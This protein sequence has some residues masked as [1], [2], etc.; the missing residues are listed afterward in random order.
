M[1]KNM[2]QTV[3]FCWAEQCATH[4]TLPNIIDSMLGGLIIT[5]L[6]GRVFKIRGGYIL[7]RPHN[8]AGIR[9][10]EGRN[11]RSS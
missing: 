8:K 5:L 2:K 11:G 7:A 1:E 9:I 10:V 6:R 3:R 4:K